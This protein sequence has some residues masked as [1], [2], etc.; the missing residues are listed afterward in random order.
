MAYTKEHE[1]EMIKS[2]FHPPGH[3]KTQAPTNLYDIQARLNRRRPSLD[4]SDDD[5]P[6]FRENSSAAKS[7]RSLVTLVVSNILGNLD[8]P[9]EQG[10]WFG[11]LEKFTYS[12]HMPT[13]DFYDGSHPS[14]IECGLLQELKTLIIPSA[15]PSA[16]VLPTFLMSIAAPSTTPIELN[17]AA[18]CYGAVAARGLHHLRCRIPQQ[19]VNN[20]QA[21]VLTAT[22][23]AGILSLYTTHVVV[24]TESAAQIETYTTLCGSWNLLN[25]TNGFRKGITALRNAREWAR[26][27]RERFNLLSKSMT[28]RSFVIIP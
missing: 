3:P 18:S 6:A 4:N 28:M 10:I 13:P 21:Y 11:N 12:S 25:D 19:T 17:R 22:F 15:N 9:H 16:A 24:A 14:E 2:G 20:K 27:Q 26:D 1:Q 7:K 5:Y 23:R 8:I